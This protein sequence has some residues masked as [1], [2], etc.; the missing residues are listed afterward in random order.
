MGKIIL[1]VLLAVVLGL[2]A[3]ASAVNAVMLFPREETISVIN[4]VIGLGILA[5]FSAATAH[6]LVRKVLRELRAER[7][8]PAEDI[9]D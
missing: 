4:G 6:F 1:Q 7:Q 5:I 2:V 8:P 3:V 9:T